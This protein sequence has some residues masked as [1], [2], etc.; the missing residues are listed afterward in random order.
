MKPMQPSALVVMWTMIFLGFCMGMRL[1][2][3]WGMIRLQ[4]PHRQESR[5]GART[6]L[7]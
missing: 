5:P 2:E 6:P 1:E 7:L 4:L 3:F